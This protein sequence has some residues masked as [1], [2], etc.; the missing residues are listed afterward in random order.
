[1][2]REE[3]GKVTDVRLGLEGHGILTFSVQLDF[4]GSGQAFGG[5][6]LDTYDKVKKRRVGAACGTDMI[7]RLLNLFDV[8]TLDRIVGRSVFALRDGD[9]LSSKIIGLKTPAFDGGK[10]LMIAD[11]QRDWFPEEGA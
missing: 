8:D 9:S 3:L 7:L 10:A 11:W 4:G 2:G 6:G 5:Y 1:V